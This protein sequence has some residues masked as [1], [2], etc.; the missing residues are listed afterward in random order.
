VRSLRG[1]FVVSSVVVVSVSFVHFG[2]RRVRGTFRW[3]AFLSL[4]LSLSLRQSDQS[5]G[6][7]QEPAGR[8]RVRLRGASRSSIDAMARRGGRSAGA[9][10]GAGAGAGGGASDAG[11]AAAAAAAATAAVG[12]GVGAAL[13]HGLTL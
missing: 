2:R 5:L 6:L 7:L 9:G 10:E 11:L 12:V 4:S 3:F 1:A 8:R 13:R